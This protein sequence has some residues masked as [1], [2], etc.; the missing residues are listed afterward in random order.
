M[1]GSTGHFS[2]VRG[3]SVGLR[4]VAVG[5]GLRAC[6]V[7]LALT[8]TAAR[9][10][11]PTGLRVALVIGNAAYASAPL[12]NSTNDA[13]AMGE[14][15]RGMGFRVIE[16]RDAGKGQ[17][18]AAIAEARD[19][20]KGQNGIGLFYFAGHGLQLDWRNYM[21]PVDA[22]PRDAGEVPAQAVDVQSVLDAFKTAGNRMNIIVLDACR[23]NPFTGRASGK[24]LAPVD[25]PPGTLLAYATAPGNVA[26]D[27][28]ASSGNGLYTGHLVQEIKRGDANIEDVFKRVRLQVRKQSQGRQVPWES[29]SL[30]ERFS[31][32]AG[33]RAPE[34][35]DEVRRAEAF[36]RELAQW[37]RIRASNNPDDF[38][39]YLREHPNGYISEQA[40]FRLDQL[41]RASVAPQARANGI[42]ELPS[43]VRRYRQG[44][45]LTYDRIDG[46]T[47][48]KTRTVQRVTYADDQ[49]AEINRGALVLDQMGGVLRNRYGERRPALV[50]APA[51]LAVGKRWTSAFTGTR[52]DGVVETSFSEFHVAALEEIDVPEGRIKAYRVERSGESS[53]PRGGY[54]N[55]GGTR[56]IDPVRMIAVR[57]DTL[58]R[59]RAGK[60]TEFERVELVSFERG[61]PSK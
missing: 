28:T 14:V 11:A 25:A 9:A 40:Q 4:R 52:P 2:A 8:F 15:L 36:N 55:L 23:D 47:K 43:G 46:W 5:V 56:W 37:E 18:E 54:T 58:F 45:V 3:L 17:M 12:I 42:S 27:G 19:A 34:K 24:G 30:E 6:A 61:A 59:D 10:Q 21:L 26:E 20:L 1:T 13:K 49:R 35:P 41:Q 22:Q 48:N 33:I 29:T 60:I 32:G 44:D 31:F 39:A 16:A 53:D 38:Y 50:V 7:G 57:N 51:G